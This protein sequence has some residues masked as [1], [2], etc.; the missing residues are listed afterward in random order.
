VVFSVDWLYSYSFSM[1]KSVL[2][3]LV[4]EVDLGAVDVWVN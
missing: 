3:P 1:K 2:F 4:F